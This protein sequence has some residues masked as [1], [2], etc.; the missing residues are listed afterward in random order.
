MACNSEIGSQITNITAYAKIGDT[1]AQTIVLKLNGVEEELIDGDDVIYFS[2]KEKKDSTSYTLQREV[3]SFTVD[4]YADVVFT[5]EETNTLTNKKYF[6][7]CQWSRPSTNL[8][9]TLFEGTFSV[10]TTNI[11]E[12]GA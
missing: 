11:T 9:K 4:G 8:V 1:W 2:I 5:E 12:E 6:Y 3:T 7:D 10:N